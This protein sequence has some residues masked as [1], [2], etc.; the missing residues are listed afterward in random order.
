MSKKATPRDIGGTVKRVET[1]V[2]DSDFP[3]KHRTV[4]T[5]LTLPGVDAEALAAFEATLSE[6]EILN[7]IQN[8]H[9]LLPKIVGYPEHAVAVEWLRRAEDCWNDS[10]NPLL[11]VALRDIAAGDGKGS[12]ALGAL[13]WF[14]QKLLD[15]LQRKNTREARAI[16]RAYRSEGGK[17]RAQNRREELADRDK[18]ILDDRGR[19]L[20]EGAEPHELAGKLAA[21]S[22]L[23]AS[24]V[25]RIFKKAGVS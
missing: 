12:G 10:Q 8:A 21:K 18:R 7:R 19:M 22:G 13:D 23:D 11:P 1:V 17:A 6:L 9:Q 20:S 3:V 5:T 25:R 24:T 14:A 4:T 15:G 16:I 2:Q